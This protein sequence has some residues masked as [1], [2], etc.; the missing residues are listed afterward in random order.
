MSEEA[1]KYISDALEALKI[2]YSFMEW[3]IKNGGKFP[4]PYFVG[5]YT[6]E[7]PLNED[8]LQDSTFIL[9]GTT[10]GT[11]L[12]LEQAKNKIKDKFNPISGSTVILASGAGLAVFYSDSFPVPTE[13][14][15]LKRIQ[16]NLQVKEWS[17][18]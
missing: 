11:W 17:V 6:E 15:N 13:D 18:K 5:E 7:T 10:R 12:S 2:P 1:L 8:G 16:I 4:D 9:T 14:E 3:R